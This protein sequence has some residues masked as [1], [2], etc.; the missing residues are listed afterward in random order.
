MEVCLQILTEVEAIS[1]T[2]HTIKEEEIDMQ[3]YS[4]AHYSA[5]T[6]ITLRTMHGIMTRYVS[7]A[8]RSNVLLPHTTTK[9][10]S[11]LEVR[12]SGNHFE[13][14]FM[15]MVY[16]LNNLHMQ[17]SNRHKTT[18]VLQRGKSISLEKNCTWK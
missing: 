12:R 8:R 5:T 17:I 10:V 9:N 18:H 15:G 4:T 6:Y 1:D 2:L 14:T 7:W 16:L 13:H 11:S 3:E